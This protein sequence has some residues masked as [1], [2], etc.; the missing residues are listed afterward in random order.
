MKLAISFTNLGPY[1]VARLRAL[2]W[3]LKAEGGEL[4]AIETAG[5]E[6]RYPWEAPKG[7]EPFERVTLFPGKAVEALTAGECRA[8]MR[9]V[10]EEEEPGAVAVSG[11]VRAEC[12]AAAAWARKREAPAVLMSESQAID[13]PRA[14]WKEAVKRRRV[15]RFDAALVGGKRHWDYLVELGMRPEKVAMGYNAVDHDFFERRSDELRARGEA[16]AQAGD[17]PYFLSVCR[18]VPEKNL[19]ALVRAYSEYRER[20]GGERAWNLALCG[21]G[22]LAESL[23]EL[24]RERGVGDFVLRPGFMQQEGLDCWYAFASAFVLA[25]RSEPWGLVANEAAACGLPLLL[26]NRCGCALTLIP[27]PAGQ[28]GFTFD[29]EDEE[30]LARLMELLTLLPKESRLLMGQRAR[31]VAR[32]WGPSRFAEGMME[33]LEL[34]LR[35]RPVERCRGRR[36]VVASGRDAGALV[37]EGGQ[38]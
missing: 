25:S 2:A 4:L 24:C 34:A 9:R 19:E 10:L 21:A 28:T 5:S 7:E 1:H 11:Y 32:Q 20:V 6:L 8:G 35:G 23:D 30:R 27:E 16:P 26:S 38:R 33:A 14:W 12:L 37:L 22:P 13:R 15:A 31:E 17:R 3:A 18:F 29:S 36:V